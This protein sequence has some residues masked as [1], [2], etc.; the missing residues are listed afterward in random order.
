M[1]LKKI[2]YKD[3]SCFS[4]YFYILFLIGL[5]V[6]IFSLISA[7][8]DSFNYTENIIF[9]KTYEH[10]Y[11]RSQFGFDKKISLVEDGFENARKIA[12]N[13]GIIYEKC[14]FKKSFKINKNDK[15][16]IEYLLK[17]YQNESC[18]PVIN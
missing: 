6:I 2:L 7:I 16:R 9:L 3:I 15:Q 12:G 5:F 4:H 18:P 1:N 11:M 17:K 8:K 14:K 13:D 10:V